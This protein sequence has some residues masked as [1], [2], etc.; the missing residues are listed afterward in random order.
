MPQLVV[1]NMLRKIT[2]L[3]IM[4]IFSKKR[5]KTR[6]MKTVMESKRV[7]RQRMRYFDF[8]FG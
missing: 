7:I 5:I 2:V 1:S 6:A 8:V 3:L 4:V